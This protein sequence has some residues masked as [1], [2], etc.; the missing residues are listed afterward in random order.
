MIDAELGTLRTDSTIDRGRSIVV[1]VSHAHSQERYCRAGVFV[2]QPPNMRSGGS[3]GGRVMAP[4][5]CI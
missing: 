2:P 4:G 1:S 5:L 3:G